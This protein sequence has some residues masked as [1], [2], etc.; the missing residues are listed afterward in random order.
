MEYG[1]TGGKEKTR[2]FFETGSREP[3]TTWGDTNTNSHIKI[4]MDN[5]L[6]HGSY[7][8]TLFFIALI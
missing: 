4:Y 5:H 7:M 1:P 8:W 2:F 6:L 3:H